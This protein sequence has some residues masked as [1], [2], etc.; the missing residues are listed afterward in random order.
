MGNHLVLSLRFLGDEQGLARF[1]GMSRGAPEWPPAPARVFQA[2]VA[3]VARGDR[4]PEAVS[5]ALERLEALAPPVIA[6]PRAARG[7]R[8]SLFVPNNDAD[9]LPDPLDPSPI[10]TQKAVEPSLFPAREPLLYAWG[11]PADFEHADTIMEAAL[12]LYQLGR[13]VDL[14]WAH[15]EVLDDEAW[16]SLLL[17]YPGEVHRPDPGPGGRRL[18]CPTSGSL[19][20]LKRRHQ[21]ALLR[22]DGTGRN[23][24]VLFTN[25]PKPRFQDVSYDCEPR[26]T[27]YQL[28]DHSDGTPWPWPLGRVVKLV[29][30]LR[31][32]AAAR[33]RASLPDLESQVERMIMGRKRDG[34]DALP[35]DQRI[36]IIPLPSIGFI[37]ADRQ[38]R[39]FLLHVP[40]G[41]PVRP[42]DVEWAF[43]ALDLSAGSADGAD[44]LLVVRSDDEGMLGHYEGPSRRWRTVT[45]V[46]L[47]ETSRRRRIE[48]TL[49]L[50]EAKGAQE[51]IAEEDRAVAAVHIALR[52]AAVRGIAQEVRVQRE[53]FDGRGARAEA[54]AEGTRFEKERL[55]H[56]EITFDRLI[57]GPL[58]IG[59]GRFLGLGVM[60]PSS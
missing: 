28:R 14:A 16:E 30:A 31:D 25:P 29:E 5:R 53:P 44:G 39:R 51:R 43:S 21:T 47:P 48:P 17:N 56:V 1:H 15:G 52:Q 58:V 34:R 13:G 42:A 46:A 11:L 41:G 27:V 7:Q 40:T 20:S 49:R 2:M 32:G 19:D 26:R 35:I 4:I 54:F 3:G 18:A 22:R 50:E 6:A 36:R 12:E 33:L 59:D 60:A 57:G 10:R 45:P 23:A 38:I 55:W 24:R 8:F 9:A 37:Y